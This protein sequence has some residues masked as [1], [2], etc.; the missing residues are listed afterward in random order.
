MASSVAMGY[1]TPRCK[2]LDPRRFAMILR[3]VFALIL[4]LFTGLL[5]APAYADTGNVIA[6]RGVD[7]D[8]TAGNAVDAREQAVLQGQRKGL[9][10]ALLMLAPAAD[11][12]RI[13][14]LSDSQITD[15]VADYDVESEQTSTVRYIGKLAFRYRVDG[16]TALLQ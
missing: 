10:Q 16:L 13:P 1:K 7:V 11:V 3:A 4:C 15:L 2:I 5:T 9:R 14:P 6:V 8:V 12:D